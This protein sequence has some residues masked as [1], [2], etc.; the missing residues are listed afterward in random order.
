MAKK[1]DDLT[2]DEKLDLIVGYLHRMDKRD[3]LRMVGGFFRGLIGILPVIILLV[4]V[5][6]FYINGDQLIEKISSSA[7]EQAARV[8][9]Q[10][11]NKIID[12]L[13][14]DALLEQ[15]RGQQQ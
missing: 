12:V 15:F 14:T 5:Y 9:S 11:A 6:Y 10:N 2:T 4:S 1:G 7:A 13:D 8:T 3:R